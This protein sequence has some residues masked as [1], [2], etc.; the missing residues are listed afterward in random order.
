M[1]LQTFVPVLVLGLVGTGCSVDA[2]SDDSEGSQDLQAS[3][4]VSVSGYDFRG[5]QVQKKRASEICPAVISG[6]AIACGIARGKS[7]STENCG[8]LCSVPIA[9]SDKRAGF[10]FAGFE[11]L[12]KPS[13]RIF[14]PQVIGPEALA[15]ERVGGASTSAADRCAS[16]C[17][18]PI[19]RPGK[20]AGFTFD[21]FKVLDIPASGLLCPAVLTEEMAACERAGGSRSSANNCATVCSLPIAKRK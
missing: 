21:G 1:K 19:A 11:I 12:N 3:S 5:P 10:S 18:L 4:S 2:A 8:T 13:S 6:E 16:L 7:V 20:V 17:S 15:C 14:C 9:P